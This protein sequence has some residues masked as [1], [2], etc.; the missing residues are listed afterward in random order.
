[1]EPGGALPKLVT[2]RN[3][4]IAWVVLFTIALALPALQFHQVESKD[5]PDIWRGWE[6]LILGWLGLFYMQ[7]AW[8]ANFLILPLFACLWFR[9]WKACGILAAI[10]VALALT[11]FSCIGLYLPRDEGGVQH[12]R[13]A[14][15]RI[16]FCFWVSSFAVW[17]AALANT[18]NCARKPIQTAVNENVD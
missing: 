1:M 15:L 9:K 12:L 8:L 5:P 18:G 7:P 10:A 14:P 6:V 2:R 3:L 11:S 16:G 4:A 13:V 17:L